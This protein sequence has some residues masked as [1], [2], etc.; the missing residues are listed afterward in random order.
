MK[1]ST[2]S[3]ARRWNLFGEDVASAG[4]CRGEE[5]SWAGRVSCVSVSVTIFVL[6]FD[7]QLV[8]RQQPCP[9]VESANKTVAI[10]GKA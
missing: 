10:Y 1:L 9:D 5:K 7:L 8:I 3:G 4:I 2:I 6:L